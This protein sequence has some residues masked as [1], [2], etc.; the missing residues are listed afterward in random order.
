MIRNWRLVLTPLLLA[1]IACARPALGQATSQLTSTGVAAPL[2]VTLQD[3]LAR[4]K[5]NEPQFHAAM[6]DYGVAREQT[7]QARAALLP[8]VSYNAAFLYTQGNGTPTGRFIGANGVHEYIN[9][10]TAQQSLSL[11]N[12]ADYRLARAQEALAKAKSEIA[13][14]GLEVTVVGAYY[15][16][17]VAQRKYS[18]AQQAASEA[19]R[20]FDITQRLERGGEVAHSDTIKARL[21]L[22]T[23]QRTLHDAQLEMGRSRL[24]LAVLIFPNF[25]EDFT[26]VDDLE[27]IAPLP[28]YDEAEKAA[29]NLNPQLRVALSSL[30]AAN[31]EVAAAWNN[32]LPSV[33]LGYAYGIDA[34]HFAVSGFD[35]LRQSFH[36]LGYSANA[37]LELPI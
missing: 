9:Q 28:S 25:N 33:T 15:G 27:N 24:E 36:N 4:A 37:T 5:I 19:E 18:T 21:Q 34:S 16:A 12:V 22:Q 20:F 29:G 14:R 17:V 2:T 7:V 31:Q 30:K 13:V 23:Q 35:P 8:N 6:T 26:T 32:F 1:L 11:A 3:A 10:G